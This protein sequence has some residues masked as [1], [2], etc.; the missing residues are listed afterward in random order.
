MNFQINITQ[1]GIKDYPLHKHNQYEIMI[2]LFG[3]GY[4]K[5][6]VGNYPFAPYSIIIIPPGLEHGSSS[7][8]GFKN[9]SVTGDFNQKLHFDKPVV[10]SDNDAHEG[11]F[12]AELIY[13]NRYINNDYLSSLCSAYVCFILNNLTLEDN[14]SI[15]VN[16][17]ISE[18]SNNFSNHNFKLKDLL[19]T[20]GY[21]ED[22]IRSCF[23]KLTNR[24]PNEFLTNVRIKHACYLIEIYANNMS[25]S[26][27]CEQCGYTDYVYFSKKFKEVVGI[28]P[29]DYKNN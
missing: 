20:S 5:T 17:I 6:S 23:K 13:N 21:A 14:M 2:Y 4:M 12:L 1:D 7:E 22:Y 15:A 3:N 26:Q 9:I 27:I 25:L 10:L 28:S 11:Q 29:K 18:I 16:K 8:S 24:T 19:K